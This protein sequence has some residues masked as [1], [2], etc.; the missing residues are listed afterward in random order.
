MAIFART[1]LFETLKQTPQKE[2][3]VRSQPKAT[4]DF[5]MK[6]CFYSTCSY[7]FLVFLSKFVMVSA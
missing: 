3:L 5:S 2:N 1:D 7:I 6:F 4:I